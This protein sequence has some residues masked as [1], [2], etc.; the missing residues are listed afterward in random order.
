MK[1][2]EALIELRK[3]EKRKFDQSV[4]L[5]INLKSIDL[6]R[7]QLNIVVNIPHKSKDKKICAF[8]NVKSKIIDSVT[9]PEFQKYKDKKTLKNLVNK[10]DY[11]IAFAPLMPKVA[12]VFGKILGPAG[13][14]PSPQLGMII[15][16][17]DDEVK[18]AINKI[19]TSLKIRLKE[20][21]IKVGV[22]KEDMDDKKIIENVKSIYASVENTLPKKRENIRN[23]MIKLS[24]TKPIKVEV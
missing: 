16:E 2:E 24:M 4:D 10:Y 8:L 18:K 11:F 9:E 15:H 20:A 12:T 21:S 7:D 22:G 23:I 5:I 19:S 6:K 13:K 14:M 17:T 3:I 1:I